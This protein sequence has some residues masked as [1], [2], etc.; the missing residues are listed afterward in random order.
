MLY[1]KLNQL[2][3]YRYDAEPAAVEGPDECTAVLADKYLAINAGVENFKW[4]DL[5]CD[6]DV[7]PFP[8]QYIIRLVRQKKKTKDEIWTAPHFPWYTA[9][10]CLESCKW[11]CNWKSN[12]ST[13]K[14][15]I[16]FYTQDNEVTNILVPS[17]LPTSS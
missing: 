13:K 5:P 17:T 6:K 10:T 11:V 2:I 14:K 1:L 7:M 4:V 8:R 3:F 16:I 15:N 12:Q 9:T